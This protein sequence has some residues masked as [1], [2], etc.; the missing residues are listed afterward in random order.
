MNLKEFKPSELMK[1]N[2]ILTVVIGLFITLGVVSCERDYI[3]PEAND[4][5]DAI[6]VASGNKRIEKGNITS[7]SDLSKGVTNRT[8][9]IP[10]SATIINSNGGNASN[11]D[12][13]HVKFDVPGEYEVNLKSDFEVDSIALDTTFNVMVLD[14][15]DTKFE[16]ASIDAGFSEQTAEQITMYEGG[17]IN[18]KDTSLGNP[19]RR[20]WSLPGG[21]PSSAG[22]I[23]I[24]EDEKVK[25]IAVS[26]PTIGT[27]DLRL[28]TWRQYPEG[29]KDTL[30]LENYIN[31]VENIDPPTL[32]ELTESDA[33]VIHLKYNLPL[34]LTGDLI[35]NLTLKVDGAD[36]AISSAAI[37]EDDNRIVDI[38]PAV[39]ARSTSVAT[40][41]YD[42]A[43][44]LTRLNDVAAEAFTDKVVGLFVPPNLADDTIYG[45]EDGGAGWEGSDD[46]MGVV[47]FTDEQAASGMYSMRMEATQDMKWT[48]SWSWKEGSEFY[49]EAG[50]VVSIEFKMWI[51]PSFTDTSVGPWI[52]KTEA[53]F[54]GTQFWT[55]TAGLPRSEWVTINKASA[56]KWTVPET[57]TYFVAF[58]FQKKGVLYID[59]VKVFQPED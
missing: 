59:D 3:T 54:P 49:L 57:G 35:P 13:I 1:K 50:T 41:S 48:R 32:M 44:G 6:A 28:V 21:D 40:L 10:E 33:G 46:N 14:Y 56:K 23:S 58:R 45:F 17:T 47:T 15:I 39:N 31:I 53:P 4:F 2:R 8:W 29:T 19:N 42:G 38:V 22:G 16:I 5:S 20:L 24:E 11:L 25:N 51:D 52:T 37:N 9:T 34:K 36:A 27:Y 26:Y 55:G 18:F 43:G 7:F 30:F 12:L